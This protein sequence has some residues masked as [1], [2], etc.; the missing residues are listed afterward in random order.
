MMP[1]QPRLDTIVMSELS[2][3]PPSGSGLRVTP[4]VR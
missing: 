4:G 3:D 2:T 1:P